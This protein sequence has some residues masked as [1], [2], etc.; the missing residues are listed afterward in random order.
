MNGHKFPRK[1]HIHYVQTVHTIQYKKLGI[2]HNA[3]QSW[4]NLKSAFLEKY[5]PLSRISA[6]QK[7]IYG[8]KQDVMESFYDYWSRFQD[9]IDKCPNHQIPDKFLILYFNKGLLP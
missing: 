2:L 3:Y 9:M 4:E 7:E 1:S 8:A 6:M 5:C